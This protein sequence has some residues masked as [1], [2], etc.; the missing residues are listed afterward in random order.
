MI[1]YRKW[2]AFGTGV[3]IEV[4]DD[5]L[6]VTIVRVRP[7]GV[8]VQGSALVA[9]YRKRQASDWGGELNKF[10]REV[11]AGHIAATV[12]LPRRDVIVRHLE[13][14]GVKD[15]DLASAVEFQLDG[16][17]PFA[18]GEA[19]HSFA[20][21]GNRGTVLVA[22]VRRETIEKF[23]ALFAEAGI[24][25]ASFTF[26]AAAVYAA[27]RITVAGPRAPE[28]VAVHQ[29]PAGFE[30][31]GESASY[32]V[33]SVGFDTP[34]ARAVELAIAELRL[35]PDTS[36][37]LLAETLPPPVVFPPSHDPKSPDFGAHALPYAT[38]IAGACPWLSL[39]VNLLPEEHRKSSSRLR[40]IPAIVLA[41]LLVILLLGLYVQQRVMDSRYLSLLQSE[42]KKYET[43]ARHV[44]Q[45]ES[46]TTLVRTR[47]FQLDEFKRRSRVDLD[48]L[49]EL[50]RIMNPPGWVSNLELTRTGL[51]L[52]GE[53]QAAAELLKILDN[54][55]Y[56]QGSEFVA[57]INRTTSGEG[58]QIRS[59]REEP[60]HNAKPQ[61]VPAAQQTAQP[62]QAAS[63]HAAPPP[64]AT[65]SPEVRTP[66]RGPAKG[67]AK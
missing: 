41:S 2:L 53:T 65:P 52:S 5:E 27:L 57:G 22:I 19:V 33:F 35:A 44:G 45:L 60:P 63:P 26:S 11:G 34:S 31:Y 40:Y 3:G 4:R 66:P 16:L 15:S 36:P 37:V 23:A 21:I 29:S 9:G 42:V 14:P 48:T 56:F 20:R 59:N 13:M 7:T 58:F 17:H 67:A 12:V 18:D 28:F 47:T 49:L 62:A 51:R 64:A 43:E 39:P 30:L 55:P 8:S 50:T 24:K 25:V 54:S 61:P 1:P 6:E 32:P 46:R 38:A 10:L